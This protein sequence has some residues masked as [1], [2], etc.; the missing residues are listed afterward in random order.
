VEDPQHVV[1]GG[2]QKLGRVGPGS[3]LGEDGGV[4]VA[5][6]GHERKPCDGI[7]DLPSDG[8][9]RWI[10][11]EEAVGMQIG[12]THGLVVTSGYDVR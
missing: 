4:D 8:A 9:S 6:H 10:S 12:A 2:N 11:R 7:E 5:M 1:V 3:V